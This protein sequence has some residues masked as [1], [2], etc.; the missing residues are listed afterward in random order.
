MWVFTTFLLIL[1]GTVKTEYGEIHGKA[2]YANFEDFP[3][4]RSKSGDYLHLPVSDLGIDYK[5]LY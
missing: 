3:L 2:E 4:K 1:S 5:V